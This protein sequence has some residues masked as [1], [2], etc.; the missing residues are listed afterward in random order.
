[1]TPLGS[2]TDCE[3]LLPETNADYRANM[4]QDIPSTF[5]IK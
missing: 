1:M 3:M 5:A 2:K 4:Y